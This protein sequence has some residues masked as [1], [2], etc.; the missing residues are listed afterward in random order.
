MKARNA[1]RVRSLLGAQIVFNHKNST[2]DCQ[3]RNIS[4][5]GAKLVI[6]SAVT[7]PEEFDLSVPQ[8]GRI[9]RA[10]LRW[11]IDESAGVEFVQDPPDVRYDPNV[12]LIRALELENQTLRQKISELSNHIEGLERAHDREKSV[13]N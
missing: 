10:R 1:E 8:K 12:D 11:R 5:L 13:V 4:A 7:L 2:L 6:S 3:V 9:Y